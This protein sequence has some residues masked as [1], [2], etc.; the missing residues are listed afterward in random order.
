[1]IGRA[2]DL[3][4]WPDTPVELVSGRSH[5]GLLGAPHPGSQPRRG[6]HCGRTRPKVTDSEVESCIDEVWRVLGDEPLVVGALTGL[7]DYQLQSFMP[8]VPPAGR[9]RRGREWDGLVAT[10]GERRCQVARRSSG[11]QFPAQGGM[12]DDEDAHHHPEPRSRLTAAS[13]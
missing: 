12:G 8:E 5:Q 1:M 11:S 3:L 7:R 13:R 2:S 4:L 9:Q 10:A 6:S